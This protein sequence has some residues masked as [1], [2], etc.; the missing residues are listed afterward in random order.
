ML[1]LPYFTIDERDM[2][3]EKVF[4]LL[5][6]KGAKLDH[7]EILK[8]LDEAGAHVDFDT[9]QVKFPKTLLEQALK[10]VPKYFKLSGAEPQFDLE[11]PAVDGN[12]LVRTGTGAPNIV[13]V[14]NNYRRVK[15]SDLIE[16][17]RLVDTLNEINFCAFPFPIDV[18]GQ[19][20]DIH[21]LHT[22]LQNT[23]KHIWVQPYSSDSIKYLLE[24]SEVAAGGKEALKERGQVSFITCALTPLEF[25]YMD[26]EII[27]QACRR[28][29]PIHACSLP[30]AG[31]TAPFTMP[32]VVL[33]SAAEILVMLSVAQIVQPKS[34]AIATP[35]IFSLD[36]ATGRTLQSSVEA[37]LGAA[38]AV[39]FLKS[40]FSVPTHTY[41]SGSD[42]PAVDGQ[43]MSERSI[44][45]LMIALAGADILGGAG[46][47]EVATTI[48][49]IQLMIDNELFG[50]IKKIVKG[51]TVNND[52]MAWDDLLDVKFGGHFLE[53]M[54]TLKHCRDAF[55][56]TL[57]TRLSR[58]AWMKQGYKDLLARA[59]EAY[60]NFKSIE[61]TEHLPEDILKGLNEIVEAADRELVK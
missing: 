37:M 30:G 42:S 55:K 60:I 38:S 11:I 49:P 16:W 58:D 14:D 33:L 34:P 35:L 53:T 57:Y 43:S 15:I 46:Q 21:A 41:G 50:M 18:P 26:L 19:T 32:S 4:D 25:K 9:K 40:A 54:H 10:L 3:Q 23:K 29:V 27:L 36:M 61:R 51:L 22:M 2:L 48:S 45:G 5:E 56:N 47:L 24:I 6:Q 12:F 28:G 59:K 17:A 1:S 31:G 44:L 20:A 52:S 8:I 7:L 39:W 13:D